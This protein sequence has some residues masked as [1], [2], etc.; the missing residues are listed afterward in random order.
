MHVRAVDGSLLRRLLATC[1]FP[2]MEVIPIAI[3]IELG[4]G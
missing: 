4:T 3:G 1:C 2:E